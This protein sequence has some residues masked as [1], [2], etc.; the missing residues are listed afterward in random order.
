MFQEKKQSTAMTGKAMSAL[1]L[2]FMVTCSLMSSSSCTPVKASSNDGQTVQQDSRIKRSA[3]PAYDS[4]ADIINFEPID[5]QELAYRLSQ[6]RGLDLGLSRGFSG[7]QAAKHMLGIAAAS[8]PNGPG[9]RS[10]RAQY[11]V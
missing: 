2:L 6:K 8:M 5:Y 7:N 4:D 11:G 3:Y 9:K 1:L 10:L